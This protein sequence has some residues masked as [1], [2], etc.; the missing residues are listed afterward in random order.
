MPG[1]FSK[2]MYGPTSAYFTM[3]SKLSLQRT[4][5]KRRATELN[6]WASQMRLFCLLTIALTFSVYSATSFSQST[7]DG[8]QPDLP[9][10]GG[11]G[12]KTVSEA[13]ESLKAKPGVTVNFTKPGN[14]TII[15][16]PGRSLQWS[17]TPPGHYAYPAVVRREIKI[18]ANGDVYIETRA[19]CQ[20][21][22]AACD[23]LLEE[24]KQLNERISVDVQQRIKQSA[25]SK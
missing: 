23:K 15:N 4:R 3:S 9:P 21:D 17:F 24:F 1:A 13:L 20:A 16:E 19:L 14:W 25:E 22:Q 2:R 10:G 12:Y 7:T 11:V 8:A 5:R 6:R 18:R